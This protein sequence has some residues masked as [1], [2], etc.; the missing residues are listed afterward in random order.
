MSAP[1]TVGVPTIA[2]VGRPNVGKSTLFNRIVGS[3]RSIVHDEPG[4]TRDAV[5]TVV[6]VDGR[7][8][9]FVD[10]AGLR[11]GARVDEDTEF[12]SSL[13]TMRAVE[14]SDVAV[15]LIDATQGVSRQALRI[16]DEIA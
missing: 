3:E 5:D 15:L 16:A 9:R 13:R 10:T 6:Q 12:Y 2:I 4:T 14:R 11:R 1:A 8:Y 7:T